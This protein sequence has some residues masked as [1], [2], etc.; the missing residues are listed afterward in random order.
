MSLQVSWSLSHA[1]S[2]LAA[3]TAGISPLHESKA[4]LLSMVN[5]S[6]SDL[7]VLSHN[8]QSYSAFLF[9]D[10]AK[11]TELYFQLLPKNIKKQ[12]RNMK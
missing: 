6:V 10:K 4:H 12:Q 5:L 2:W 3:I 8:F 7:S 1:A 11:W 9:A